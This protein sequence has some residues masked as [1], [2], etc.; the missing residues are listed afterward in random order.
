[1]SF[2]L[3]ETGS[4]GPLGWTL[5]YGCSSLAPRTQE[6]ATQGGSATG[7]SVLLEAR[8]T[9]SIL[10]H[11][12]PRDGD[13][14]EG[15]GAGGAEQDAQ[16][17]RIWYFPRGL[18]CGILLSVRLSPGI[19]T[20][21]AGL[22]VPEDD[23]TCLHGLPLPPAASPSTPR[24]AELWQF[25]DTVGSPGIREFL[26]RRWL[27]EATDHGGTHVSFDGYSDVMLAGAFLAFLV[28]L[29]REA[30][31]RRGYR[32]EEECPGRSGHGVSARHCSRPG[33]PESRGGAAVWAEGWSQRLLSP[34]Q[35]CFKS[36]L[37]QTLRQVH[38]EAI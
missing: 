10:L 21:P 7:P 3:Q 2:S 23:A 22:W 5:S 28:D 11:V 37:P 18:P 4:Q 9:H 31:R 33:V 8:H 24:K 27:V 26:V 36:P 34:P 12:V 20:S 6:E 14:T 13:P 19:L 15:D 16:D 25:Q 32:E 38:S 17:E 1:M 35:A 29:Q 30:E